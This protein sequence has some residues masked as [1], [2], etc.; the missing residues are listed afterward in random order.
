MD[1]Q[2]I[3]S[4][5]M[6]GNLTNDQLNSVVAAIKYARA[7]M[8]RTKARSFRQGDRV[9]FTSRGNTYFGTV[10]RVKIKNAVVRVGNYQSYNVPVNMLEAE[11]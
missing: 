6:F 9:R 4:A 1:I 11:Q 5:I 10:E 2:A 8:A 7:Q 3:N